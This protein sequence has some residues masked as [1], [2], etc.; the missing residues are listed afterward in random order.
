MKPQGIKRLG[1]AAL[2]TPGLSPHQIAVAQDAVRN[3][4]AIAAR[5]KLAAETAMILRYAILHAAPPACSDCDGPLSPPLEQGG[6][7]PRC[8]ERPQNYDDA[9]HAHIE[10][11][12]RE[13][14]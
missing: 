10:A 14:P 11:I 12:E 9:K 7:C 13:K 2:N 1:T 4:H 5:P 3:C 8:N 6:V